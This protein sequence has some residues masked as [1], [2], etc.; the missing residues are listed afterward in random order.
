[1]APIVRTWVG[2]RPYAIDKHP[3]IGP[4]PHLHGMWIAAGHEGLGISLAPIT[5]LLLAQ[6]IVGVT[7]AIDHRPYLPARPCAAP[8]RASWS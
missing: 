6:Q 4:W 1:M 2:L 5:G 3:L 8:A 7:P